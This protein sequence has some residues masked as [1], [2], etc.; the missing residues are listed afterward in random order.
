MSEL[1]VI[2]NT[3]THKIETV[4]IVTK[5]TS[6]QIVIHKSIWLREWLSDE[7]AGCRNYALMNPGSSTAI[8]MSMVDAR[9][10]IILS[11]A[12]YTT[13]VKAAFADGSI[14]ES[15]KDQLLDF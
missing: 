6:S 9:S 2:L 15:K 1:N 11:D 12:D 4:G 7:E 13:S 8:F 5:E 10:E 3:P 14:T